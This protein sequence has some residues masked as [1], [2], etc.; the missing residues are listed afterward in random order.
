MFITFSLFGDC[1][2]KLIMK[3]VQFTVLFESQKD[4]DAGYNGTKVC[5]NF[6]SWAV[7]VTAEATSWGCFRTKTMPALQPWMSA[8]LCLS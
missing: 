5:E 7:L 3:V 6:C 8:C 1:K 4:K 2:T